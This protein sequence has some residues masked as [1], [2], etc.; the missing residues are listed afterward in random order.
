MADP[1]HPPAGSRRD[2]RTLEELG[3]AEAPREHPLL[4][5]GVWPEESGVLVGDRML[6]LGDFP[7][8]GRHPLLAVGSNGCP[9]QLRHKL[10][11]SG[12]AAPLPMVRS[13]VTGVDVGV[14]AHVSRMGYVSAS[15]FRAPTTVRELFVLWLDARQLAAV[16]ASEGVPVPTGNYERV[17]LPG[18][19]VRVE[20]EGGRALSGVS[21][22]VNRHGVLH[23][24]SGAP[25]RHP[26][27][28]ALL[29]ELLVESSRMRDLFGDT[30]ETFCARAR[31]DLRLCAR[32][33][34]LFREEERVTA[35]GLEGYARR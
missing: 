2:G 28:R 12:I 27:E 5:P 34:R 19:D 3:L 10:A 23:S 11:E 16:D 17:W 1:K 4:Y 18:S 31:A 6:P 24:G 8:A 26:G 32:G 15:P 25:R 35:S 13:R 14:S 21:V 20:P 29:T 33:T 22:Y 30:P 7:L 9:G